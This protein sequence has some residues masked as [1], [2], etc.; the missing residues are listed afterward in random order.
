MKSILDKLNIKEFNYGSCLGGSEWMNTKDS[1]IIES[2]NP[3]TGE[4][5]AKV[6]K[7][8]ESDY[9]KVIKSSTEAFNEWRMVPAPVR[10]QLILDIAN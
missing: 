8:S 4:L 7:C 6:Y 3:A 10:G 5:L 9:D 2:F 1:G